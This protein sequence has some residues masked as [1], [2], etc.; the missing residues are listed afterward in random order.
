[1]KN[2]FQNRRFLEPTW[3]ILASALTAR[4]TAAT[5]FLLTQ[6]AASQAEDKCL[7]LKFE[8]ASLY[9]LRQEVVAS[10][11]ALNAAF[12]NASIS[13]RTGTLSREVRPHGCSIRAPNATL[14]LP[15]RLAEPWK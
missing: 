5:I 13:P 10:E 6:T 4:L 15:Q 2:S 11:S 12:L 7:R 1:M 8:V 3:A 9:C 14:K